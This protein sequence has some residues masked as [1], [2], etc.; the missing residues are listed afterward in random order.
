MQK[1]NLPKFEEWFNDSEKSGKVSKF[2]QRENGSKDHDLEI[3]E[4]R[5]EKFFEILGYILS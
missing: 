5:P 3:L 4:M 2:K 1:K